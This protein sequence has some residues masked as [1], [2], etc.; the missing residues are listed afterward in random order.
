MLRGDGSRSHNS[1]LGP[2]DSKARSA[3]AARDRT[4]GET[5]LEGL[6]EPDTFLHELPL[7]PHTPHLSSFLGEST[8][9]S[10]PALT[11]WPRT[12]MARVSGPHGVP[13]ITCSGEAG[14][15]GGGQRA[16]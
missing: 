2:R 1:N 8:T 12:Q 14:V 11:H 5:H 9:W 6:R 7:P 15:G 4:S 16:Q 13:S 10:Q 3:R